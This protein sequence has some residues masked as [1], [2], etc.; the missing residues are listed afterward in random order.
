MYII[1]NLDHHLCRQRF[2][3]RLLLRP[4]DNHR[5]AATAF[6]LAL[7]SWQI[8]GGYLFCPY[9]RVYVPLSAMMCNCGVLVAT[10]TQPPFIHNTPAQQAKP[11]TNQQ[12]CRRRRSEKKRL[13]R[14]I[15]EK[16]SLNYNLLC[17]TYKTIHS[18]GDFPS[19]RQNFPP[20]KIMDDGGIQSSERS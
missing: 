9:Y 14:L 19:E 15:Q 16:P 13:C 11:T 20:T 7:L 2:L 12:Q 10:T 3:R 6:S 5:R 17:H 8:D 4:Q 18:V 1:H